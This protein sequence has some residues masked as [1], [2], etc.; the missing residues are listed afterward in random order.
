[1]NRII[2]AE[3]QQINS[4]SENQHT[5]DTRSEIKNQSQEILNIVHL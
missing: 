4:C 5:K 3:L 2:R 1:M